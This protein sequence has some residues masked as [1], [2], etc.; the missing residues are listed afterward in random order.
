MLKLKYVFK[1]QIFGDVSE[2]ILTEEEIKT[3]SL[4][5]ILNSGMIENGYELV[6]ISRS[7]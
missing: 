2:Y 4:Q 6:D 1:N 3:G 7:E 5:K